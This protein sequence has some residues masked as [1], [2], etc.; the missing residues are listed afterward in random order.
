VCRFEEKNKNKKQR[1][2]EKLSFRVLPLKTTKT[3]AQNLRCLTRKSA[4]KV[5]FQKSVAADYQKKQ[6]NVAEALK[7]I[8]SFDTAI[9]NELTLNSSSNGD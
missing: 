9:T 1:N 4:N 8:I 7:I 5:E 2:K 3:E 6:V